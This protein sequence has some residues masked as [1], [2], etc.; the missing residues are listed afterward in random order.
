MSIVGKNCRQIGKSFIKYE[1]FLNVLLNI[2]S[3]LFV[4][5]ILSFKV[6]PRSVQYIKPSFTN[7]DAS[8]ISHEK[9]LSMGNNF[10]YFNSPNSNW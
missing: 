8:Y 6:P 7:N 4:S 5:S 1:S 9:E 2:A 10:K 3:E